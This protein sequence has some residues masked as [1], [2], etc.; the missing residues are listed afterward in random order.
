MHAKEH[1]EN[2]CCN[3]KATLLR[4]T[5]TPSPPPTRTRAHAHT[6]YVGQVRRDCECC[7]LALLL[8]TVPLYCS[9]YCILHHLLFPAAVFD[10]HRAH[11]PALNIGGGRENDEEKMRLL[12]Q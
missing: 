10:R 2:T 3:S 6:T 4:M 11:I 7:C 8:S 9:F 12:S 5:N 1:A